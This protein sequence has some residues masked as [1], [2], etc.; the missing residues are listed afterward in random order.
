MGNENVAILFFLIQIFVF[1]VVC[2]F[3]LLS[4]ELMWSE[5]HKATEEIRLGGEAHPRH[6]DGASLV[7]PLSHSDP[8]VSVLTVEVTVTPF[9]GAARSRCSSFVSV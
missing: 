9:P 5:L 1:V 4:S 8:V 7:N 6:G 3:F 2:L